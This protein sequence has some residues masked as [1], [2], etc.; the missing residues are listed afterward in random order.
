M[1]I[2][3]RPPIAYTSKWRWRKLLAAKSPRIIH[4]GHEKSGGTDQGLP[5][6]VSCSGIVAATITAAASRRCSCGMVCRICLPLL[7]QPPARPW[8]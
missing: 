4:D 7:L 2:T 3:G 8:L 1:A 5:A 6:T